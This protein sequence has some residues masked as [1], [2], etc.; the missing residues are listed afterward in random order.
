MRQ[1]TLMHARLFGTL[2]YSNKI[3]L[4]RLFSRPK[5]C[6]KQGP[7]VQGLLFT[8]MVNHGI[9]LGSLFLHFK[10]KARKSRFLSSTKGE[11]NRTEL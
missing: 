2:E 11:E 5:S 8:K 7:S 1:I 10:Q 9:N 3:W 6:I 4:M